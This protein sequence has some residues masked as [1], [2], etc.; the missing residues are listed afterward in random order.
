LSF[1]S[2]GLARMVFRQNAELTEREFFQKMGGFGFSKE[3]TEA[4]LEKWRLNGVVSVFGG[5]KF[6]RSQLIQFKGE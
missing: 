3:D 2:K 6:G 5:F 4:L 1:E